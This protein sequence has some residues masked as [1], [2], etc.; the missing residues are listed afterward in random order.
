MSV[1]VLAHMH[2]RAVV[3]RDIKPANIITVEK[4]ALPLGRW[5][6]ATCIG[7]RGWKWV[8][9]EGRALSW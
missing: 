3:H 1:L 9:V 2:E 5:D 8:V 4:I 6:T 7:G